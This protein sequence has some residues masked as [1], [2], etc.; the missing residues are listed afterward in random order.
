[1]NAF[2]R[3]FLLGVVA[4]LL[5]ACASRPTV[6]PTPVTPPPLPT[7]DVPPRAQIEAAI[8]QWQRS[9]TT[10]YFVE[11]EEGDAQEVRKVRVVVIDGEVRAAQILEKVD[12]EW[13]DPRALPLDQAQQYTVDALLDRVLRDATGQGAVP[14]DMLAVFDPGLGFPAVVQANAKETYNADGELVLNREYSYRLGVSVK[15]LLEDTFGVGRDPVL[16]LRQSGGAQA[17]CDVLFLY[18]DGSSLYA[19]DCTQTLLQFQLPPK[20]RDA[21]ETLLA[22]YAPIQVERTLDG[23][24]QSLVVEA[25]GTQTADDAAL[26]AVWE[27]VG[28]WYDVLSRPIGAGMTLLFAQG[29]QVVGM[30]LHNFLA[31]PTTI[32]PRGALYGALLAPTADGIAY[33][34]ESGL[35]W[36]DLKTGDTPLLI[37]GGGAR[38][39]PLTWSPDGRLLLRREDESGVALGWA[40]VEDKTW[41]GLPLPEGYAACVVGWDWAPDG[42]RLALSAATTGETCSDAPLLAVVDV[43]ADQ[44]SALSLGDETLVGA[45]TPRW[46]VDGDWLYFSAAS[47][48]TAS[49]MRV[50]PTGDSWMTVA[51]VDQAR[52]IAPLLAP[53]KRLFYGVQGG[54]QSGIWV[55]EADCRLLIAGDNLAPISL[56]PDGDFLLYRSGKAL[57]VWIVAYEENVPVTRGNLDAQFVG[58]LAMTSP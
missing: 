23:G 37:A 38:L 30:E 5:A 25:R 24:T 41:H 9:Q 39:Y 26:A 20:E 34:D 48:E 4:L 45:Y 16:T 52:V 8:R 21:L 54:E 49:L 47:E 36:Y 18:E 3:W 43:S 29:N 58:W 6:L 42:A 56:S 13:S 14:Y 19:D 50:R 28:H 15:A 51:E 10:R 31:Q 22:N 2:R 53:D 27:Q 12:G 1:M 35:R 33:A 7:P 11:V 32:R 17:W 57:K 40:T 55:C 46:S 44:F